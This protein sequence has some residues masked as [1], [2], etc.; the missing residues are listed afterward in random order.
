MLRQI[1]RIYIKR[2]CASVN[3]HS[4]DLLSASHLPSLMLLANLSY[5]LDHQLNERK[6]H[7]QRP[8]QPRAKSLIAN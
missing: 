5:R 4:L 8:H 7:A 3:S 6:S 2:A 1:H